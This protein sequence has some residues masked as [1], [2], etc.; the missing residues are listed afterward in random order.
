M[1]LTDADL[2]R[3]E[4]NLFSEIRWVSQQLIKASGTVSGTTLTIS[5][6]DVNFDGAQLAPGM[7]VLINEIPHEVVAKLSATTAQIS[8]VRAAASDTVLVPAP[9]TG[10]TVI[11][12]TFRPQIVIVTDRVFR[13]LGLDPAQ[14]AT[15]S[16]GNPSPIVTNP[17]A[18]ARYAALATL[19]SIFSSASEIQSP[20]GPLARRAKRYEQLV[21]LE[22]SS[23]V[24]EIDADGDFL[25]DATRRASIVP[26]IRT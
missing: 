11:L 10:A 15:D 2:L 3:L 16:Q 13:S 26:L 22:R 24:A 7:V 6:F 17:E 19:A 21:S 20:D 9:I 12:H 8:R 14:P 5:S 4:P 23:L 1:L 18:L 25:P